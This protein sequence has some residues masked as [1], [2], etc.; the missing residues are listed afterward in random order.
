MYL[1]EIEIKFTR[2]DWN[3]DGGD[4]EDGFLVFSQNAWQF[5]LVRYKELSQGNINKAHWFA[6]NNY[7]E[8]QLYLKLVTL[9]SF[10]A[11]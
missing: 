8:V 4:Q 6:L 5:G 9:F 1:N 10:C 3:S 11:Y 7:A 2:P